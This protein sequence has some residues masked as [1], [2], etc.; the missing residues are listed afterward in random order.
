MTEIY[1]ELESGNLHWGSGIYEADHLA[2][3]EEFSS[4]DRC[5]GSIFEALEPGEGV[6]LQEG[7]FVLDLDLDPV[8][9]Q[10]F[11]DDIYAD[12][13]PTFFQDLIKRLETINPGFASAVQANGLATS[14]NVSDSNKVL[15]DFES[16]ALFDNLPEEWRSWIASN[17]T[18]RDEAYE[19]CADWAMRF[20]AEVFKRIK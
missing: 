17:A 11:A 12:L 10:E 16:G 3:L 2:T 14:L 13:A 7:L 1:I 15:F 20:G 8:P 19:A 6:L 4:A 9:L 5:T 18:R